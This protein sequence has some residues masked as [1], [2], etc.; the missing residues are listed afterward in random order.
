MDVPALE[1]Q[2]NVVCAAITLPGLAIASVTPAEA[3]KASAR[4]LLAGIK[5]LT[6]SP[7]SHG[8]PG[9]LLAGFVVE[10][11]LKSFLAFCLNAVAAG[12]FIYRDMVKWEYA[13]AM[14]AAAVVGG[15][16]GARLS[17][18]LPPSIVRWIVIAI[19]FSLAA[20]YFLT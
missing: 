20:Y 11:A 18:R 8:M 4:H 3:Y 16:V 12:M 10:S 6:P 19:G 7:S 14:A 13:L 5:A 15:Y 2:S 17:L 1:P 9:T